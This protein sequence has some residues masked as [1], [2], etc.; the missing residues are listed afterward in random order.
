MRMDMS[1]D[2]RTPRGAPDDFPE[3]LAG[4][5]ATSGGREEQLGNLGAPGS[6]ALGLGSGVGFAR[7]EVGRQVIERDLAQRYQAP[8]LALAERRDD[9][10]RPIDVAQGERDE[11]A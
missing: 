5:L 8:L 3:S 9:A 11:L 1:A 7:D 2:S 10:A 4:E 6:S